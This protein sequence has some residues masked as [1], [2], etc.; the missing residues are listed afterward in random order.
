MKSN[1]VNRVGDPVP[2][3]QR[4]ITESGQPYLTILYTLPASL[5]SL[6]PPSFPVFRMFPLTPPHLLPARILRH[7]PHRFLPG[8]DGALLTVPGVAGTPPPPRRGVA[9]GTGPVPPPA[10]AAL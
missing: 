1:Q 2:V 10:S 9:G 6:L 8:V 5:R 4:G 3:H 7:I